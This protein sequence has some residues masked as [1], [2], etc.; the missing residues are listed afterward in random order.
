MPILS[1][2]CHNPKLGSCAYFSALATPLH[3]PPTKPE[4]GHG[5]AFYI[6]P[7]PDRKL[8]RVLYIGH[9]KNQKL[10]KVLCLFYYTFAS[11]KTGNWAGSCVY[12]IIHLPSPKS[13]IGQGCVPSVRPVR[14]S[15]SLGFFKFP[16]EI[17]GD[18][19]RATFPPA[20]LGAARRTSPVFF[21]SFPFRNPWGRPARSPPKPA[22]G[23]A[24]RRTAPEIP[25]GT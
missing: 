25:R 23:R 1:Y 22:R 12:F 10:R 18:V 24:A 19:R 5:P 17:P 8:G 14:P 4:I 6:C 21:S 3:L 15:C 13:E 9:P 20:G 16:F 11:P 7:P 2:I